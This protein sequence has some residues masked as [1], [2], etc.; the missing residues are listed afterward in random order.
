MPLKTSAQMHVHGSDGIHAKFDNATRKLALYWG[1][2]KLYQFVDSAIA[3]CLD[4][5][6]PFFDDGGSE[7]ARA[8]DLQLI[9]DHVDFVDEEL[10]DAFLSFLNPDHKTFNKLEYRGACLI[11]FDSKSYPST[12]H[13]TMEAEVAEK[14]RKAFSNWQSKLGSGI[15]SRTPLDKFVLEVFFIPFP[16]VQSFRDFF[17][18]EIGNV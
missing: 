2:V 13:I 8:R 3:H 1:E 18:E 6:K 10:E 17:L 5:I 4:S 14:V 12:P 9:R 7:S 15:K 11:G 16:S